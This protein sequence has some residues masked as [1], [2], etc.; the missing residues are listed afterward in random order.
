MSFYN[1]NQPTNNSVIVTLSTYQHLI[2]SIPIITYFQKQHALPHRNHLLLHQYSTIIATLQ[3]ISSIIHTSQYC[4]TTIS[5][6]NTHS[7][8]QISLHPT[9]TIQ[10]HSIQQ[11]NHLQYSNSSILHNSQSSIHCPPIMN[12]HSQIFYNQ[13]SLIQ[14]N[15]LPLS[16]IS[17][18]TS[19]SYY[20]SQHF[21]QTSMNSNQPH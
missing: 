5:K 3:S 2:S 12:H 6:H 4:I 17:Q 1:S 10:I 7:L 13:Y 19:N 16:T 8:Q 20:Q 11:I 21:Q 15:S 9:H 18:H 14:P